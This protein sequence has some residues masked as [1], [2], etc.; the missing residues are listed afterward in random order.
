[1]LKIGILDLNIGKYEAYWGEIMLYRKVYGIMFKKINMQSGMAM[2]Y[3]YTDLIRYVGSSGLRL[4][5]LRSGKNVTDY[6]TYSTSSMSVSNIFAVSGYKLSFDKRDHAT[7]S[8]FFSCRQY[9]KDK[10]DKYRITFLVC[11]TH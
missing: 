7:R 9:N 1:M 2:L 6:T 10:P 5:V 11:L 4:A 3:P 8:R